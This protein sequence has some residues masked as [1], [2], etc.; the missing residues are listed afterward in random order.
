MKQILKKGEP[1]VQFSLCVK[2]STRHRNRF[3]LIIKGILSSYDFTDEENWDENLQ[4]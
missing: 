4:L 3:Y 2:C 1:F